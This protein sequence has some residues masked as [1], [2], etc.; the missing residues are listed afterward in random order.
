MV[1]L[2]EDGVAVQGPPSFPDEPA[3][4]MQAVETELPNTEFEFVGHVKHP[5]LIQ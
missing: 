1:T 2:S 3:L 5:Q 4:Q